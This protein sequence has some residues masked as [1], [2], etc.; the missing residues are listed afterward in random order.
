[1]LE[2]RHQ[3]EG[4][5]VFASETNSSPIAGA[6]PPLWVLLCAS[7]GLKIERQHFCFVFFHFFKLSTMLPVCCTPAFL[8]PFLDLG[9]VTLSACARAPL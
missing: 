4:G 2:L 5:G 7:K 6:P 9:E 3:S 8:P 1:M